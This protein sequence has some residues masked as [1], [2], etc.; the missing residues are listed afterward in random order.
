[1][2]KMF[3]DD[4]RYPVDDTWVICR[5][6]TAAILYIEQ[7]GLPVYISF[8]HDLGGN[9]TSILFINWLIDYLLDNEL[10][11][12]KDFSYYVHSQNPIG[13]ENIRSKMNGIIDYFK[14]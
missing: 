10:V 1:M 2:Y 13:A 7:N 11:L 14:E 5:N 9:D 3:I 6:S 12:P 4:E 8:D